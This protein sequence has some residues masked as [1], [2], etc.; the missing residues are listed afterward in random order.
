VIASV[1]G[2]ASAFRIGSLAGRIG[3]TVA[4]SP[5]FSQSTAG[6]LERSV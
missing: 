2:S 5:H 6:M 1:V 3:E 4:D